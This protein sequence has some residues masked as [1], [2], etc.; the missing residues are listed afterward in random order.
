MAPALVQDERVKELLELVR[1]RNPFQ[2][3]RLSGLPEEPTLDEVPPLTKRELIEDQANHPPFGTNLTYPLRRYTQLH[4]TSGTTGR[5]L[6]VLDTAEDWAWWREL[7]ADML[8]VAGVEPGDR[9]A[10]A[11]SF[12]P[13]VQFWAAREGLQELGAMGVPLGGMTSVQR[14]QTIADVRATAV[15]CTPTYALRLIEVALEERLEGALE[16]VRQVICTGEPGASLPA[17][18]S[19]I[20]EGFGARC[21]DHAGLTEAG[22]FGY[23]CPEGGGL[24]LYERDFACEILDSELRPTLPGERGELVVTP[25]R[26]TGF[27]VLRYRTGDVVVNAEDRCPAGHEDRWLPGGIVGRTDDMVVIRGMNVYPSAIEEAVRGVSG[28]GEFRITFYTEPGGMDEIKLEVE[29][30]DGGAARRLQETMRQQLGLRVRVVPV[31]HG[32]LPR[33]DGKARRVVDAR[34]ARWPGS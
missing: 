19:R 11:F 13:H 3:A 34:S 12:G 5:P 21:F 17:V 20:E 9:V 10:L 6:R 1:E 30:P 26:R 4:Q 28:S 27:P 14:L 25:L 7:F 16:S 31:T 32:T 23:P 22:P 18:R 2:R 15:M 8:S 33:M 24:H 29:L